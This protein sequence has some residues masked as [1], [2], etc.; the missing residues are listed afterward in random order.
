[1]K[2]LDQGVAARLRDFPQGIPTNR[3][4]IAATWEFAD[5]IVAAQ[6]IELQSA[7]LG[8]RALELA[9]EVRR[10]HGVDQWFPDVPDADLQGTLR[11]FIIKREEAQRAQQER[12]Q[13]EVLPALQAVNAD[14]QRDAGATGAS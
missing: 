2:W 5:P 9:R 8:K 3:R 13:Q 6:E 12:W 1:W 14:E 4:S 7:K 11:A 10:T